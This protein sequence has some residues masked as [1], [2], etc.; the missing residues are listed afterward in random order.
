MRKVLVYVEIPIL[1]RKFEMFLPDSLE[2]NVL[3]GMIVKA[4]NQMT[5]EAYPLTGEE[6]ICIRRNQKVLGKDSTLREADV[7]NGD[8]LVLI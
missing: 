2:E 4:V 1:S 8:R 5:H 3:A 7:K 6:V